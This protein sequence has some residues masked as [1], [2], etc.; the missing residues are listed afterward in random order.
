MTDEFLQ[1]ATKEINEDLCRL[2][3]FLA[4]CKTDRDVVA[5]STEFQKHTQN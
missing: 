3:H 1:V 4:L 2:E 5:N